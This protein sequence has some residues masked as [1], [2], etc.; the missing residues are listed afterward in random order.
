MSTTVTSPATEVDQWLSSFD[1]ALTAGDAAAASELFLDDSYWRDLVAFTWNIKTVEGPGG[2]QDMLEHT[3]ARTQ[4]RGWETAEEPTEA[5]GVTEAWLAFETEDGRC[6]G[7]LRLKEAR[8]GPCSPPSTS[9]RVTRSRSC[10][11]APRAS[12][13]GPIPTARPGSRRASARRRSLV[14]RPSRRC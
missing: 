8:P 13:T 7:H 2:V 11:N 14:T 12:S 9:S 1:E 6:H 3:L 5:E 4:P 10:T